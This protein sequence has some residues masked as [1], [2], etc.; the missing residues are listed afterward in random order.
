MFRYF[1]SFVYR[2]LLIGLAVCAGILL[3]SLGVVGLGYGLHN[4]FAISPFQGVIVSLTVTCFS[5]LTLSILL[6][7][8][9]VKKTIEHLSLLQLEDSEEANEEDYEEYDGDYDL[10]GDEDDL[11]EFLRKINKSRRSM[12]MNELCPCGSG[13]KRKDC[14]GKL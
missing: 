8:T 7:A 9:N 13:L 6:L 12:T 11:N 4:L 14:C 1:T 10:Y 2:G 5:G 3:V